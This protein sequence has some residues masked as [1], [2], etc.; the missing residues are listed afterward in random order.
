MKSTE[1]RKRFLEF[2][3]ARGHAI[4]PSASLV[5]ENDPSVLFN[6]AGMQ[7]LV[8]YL[9]GEKHPL[10]TRLASIQ[11]CVR[12]GDIDEIGDNTHVTFFEMMG[13][14][15]LGDYFKKDA[16]Q[17]SFEL[18]TNKEIGFGLDPQRLY[19]TC[20]EGNDDAPKDTESAEIWKN[21]FDTHGVSGERIYFMPAKNNWWSAGD[22][23]PCG[24]DTE[25]F[26]DLTGTHASGMT[27]GEYL[28]ADD[29]QEV[30]EIWNDVFME[31]LKKDGVVV[32]KL[33][34]QNVDTGSGL[35]RVTAVLQGK[36][37]IFDTDIFEGVMMEAAKIT[38]NV[39]SQRILSDHMRTATF[40]IADGVTPSNTDQGY[41]LR[42]L[43]R[44]AVFNTTTRTLSQR[45]VESIVSALVAVF[46]DIYPNI[47]EQK[48]KI[49]G[50]IVKEAEK[51][52][53]T[54]EQGVKEF[55]KLAH[56]GDISG[57]DAF[58]LFSSFGF[59]FDLTKEL[60]L[61]KGLSVDEVAFKEEFAKHQ[62][63]SR[64]GSEQKFKGGLA[65]TGEIE[66]RYHTATH[67]LHQALRDVLGDSVQQK[68]SNITAE[69]LRFDFMH[70][71]KMSDEEKKK[72]EDII[73]EKIQARLPM[74]KVV[75]KKEDAEKTGALHFFGDK[76]G[77]EVS[78]YFIGDSIE[79]AY[80]KEFCGG[81][82]VA[83]IGELGHF[84]IAKEEAVSAGVRRIKAVLS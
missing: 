46:G 11:K 36:N 57:T 82:H 51:F 69:R 4:L 78:V 56:K 26:Y 45:S 39:K 40:M 53:K 60:A 2:F 62:D 44:R 6:T 21:I 14:W 23:G 48:E 67:L 71:Q 15:S 65:G 8:P 22:N 5:P 12:T 43:I 70:A 80:S 63:L 35:E 49:I 77:D 3:K 28:V 74:Q 1:I 79:S 18:L 24:P 54:I 7:P 76:Y 58:M 37:N 31:Y 13:N 42:R 68:G 50:E 59:P 20:F 72:V 9:L 75:M 17:W 33:A 25:M 29:K 81:P 84:K 66:T 34:S 61:A 27:K 83:N 16:I 30:V 10:G 55:E 41:V 73:N 47:P 19:V 64:A 38:D 52:A 32:G